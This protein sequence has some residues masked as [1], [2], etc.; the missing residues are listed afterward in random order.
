MG[1]GGMSSL[2]HVTNDIPGIYRPPLAHTCG[3]AGKMR[4][5]RH[6]FRGMADLYDFAVSIAPPDELDPSPSYGDYRR[7]CGGRVI[8]G[9]M[10]PHSPKDRMAAGPTKRGKDSS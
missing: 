10:R 5:T 9:H 6:V 4:I 3:K 1:T 7:A 8:D 2:T